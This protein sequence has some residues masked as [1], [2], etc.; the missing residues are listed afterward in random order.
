MRS[1]CR[2][3]PRNTS[4]PKRARSK[5]AAPAAIISIAQHA[6][7]KVA[8]QTLA[9]RAHLTSSS[10]EPVRKLWLRSSRPTLLRPPGL[11]SLAARRSEPADRRRRS[12]RGLRLD[13]ADPLDRP[14]VEGPVCD[15]I[16]EGQEDGSREHEYL[17]EAEPA[18]ARRVDRPREEEDDLDVDDHED[19]SY[20][21]EAHR[22]PPGRLVGRHDSTLVWR[23][24]GG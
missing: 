16:H 4:I 13:R 20:Q 5:S 1:A 12:T 19:H 23:F 10:S 9:R 22:E 21:V 11:R 24:L 6:R 18:Q 2:G 15:E 8:G 3:E 14:P 7:P 17:D